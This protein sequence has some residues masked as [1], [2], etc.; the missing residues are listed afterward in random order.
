VQEILSAADGGWM[1]LTRSPRHSLAIE[2]S[3]AQIMG[4][5]TA[6]ISMLGK[7]ILNNS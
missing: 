7:L 2:K 5:K 1:M 3:I 4:K 6:K